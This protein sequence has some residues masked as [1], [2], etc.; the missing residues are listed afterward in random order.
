M[1][2]DRHAQGKQLEP[3]TVIPAETMVFLLRGGGT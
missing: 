1:E 2:M 3:V